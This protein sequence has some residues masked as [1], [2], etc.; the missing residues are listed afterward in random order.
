MIVHFTEYEVSLEACSGHCLILEIKN[1]D[2]C[3]DPDTKEGLIL[4]IMRWLRNIES[5]KSGRNELQ[6]WI[7][8]SHLADKIC[9][10]LE[11]A[12]TNQPR[13]T[14]RLIQ[15]TLPDVRVSLGD[16]QFVFLLREEIV[17]LYKIASNQE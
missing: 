16:R 9:F 1:D 4:A 2:G 3:I 12:Y 15:R 7:D 10:A 17:T 8:V 14:S 6:S 5:F 11:R 13:K